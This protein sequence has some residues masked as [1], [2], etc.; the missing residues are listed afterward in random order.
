M[1]IKLASLKA[2]IKAEND[3]EWI[4]LDSWAGLDPERPFDTVTGL[5]LRFL[6]RSLNASDY[7]V[8]R[9]KAVERV[10]ELR[11]AD[12]SGVISEQV[13]AEIFGTV[14]AGS[15][16]R[17]WEGFDEA[18]DPAMAKETLCDPASRSLRDMVVFCASKVGKRKLEHVED[19]AKNF[20]RQSKSR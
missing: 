4:A 15:L 16:L 9:Q 6:T 2:D 20:E 8:A 19:M 10:D 1:T 5:G 12:A 17:G 13:E 11:K 14:I 3:G 7:K 18:Y